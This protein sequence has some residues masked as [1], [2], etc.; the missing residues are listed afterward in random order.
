MNVVPSPATLRKKMCPLCASTIAFAIDSPSPAPT[1]ASLCTRCGAEEAVEEPILL[2][3]RNAHS[4]VGHFDAHARTVL[5]RDQLDAAAGRRE[6]EGVRDE[7]VDHLPDAP[8]VAR[9]QQAGLGDAVELDAPRRSRRRARLGALPDDRRGVELRMREREAAGVRLRREQEILDEAQQAVRIP[10]DHLEPFPLLVRLA[11]RLGVVGDE[12]EIAANRR[13]R[14]AQ[15]VR[16]EC[17]ELVLDAVELAQP[18]VLELRLREQRLAI[19]LGP[20]P[21]RDVEREALAVPRRSRRVA[22]DRVAVP[23]PDVPAVLGAEPVL[24]V[25]RL[26]RLARGR[27][28]AAHAVAVV[29]MQVVDEEVRVAVPLLLRVAEHRPDLGADEVG[30]LV[31]RVRRVHVRDQRQL[32]DEL[33][34][35]H[36]CLAASRDVLVVHADDARE[37]REQADDNGEDEDEGDPAGGERDLRCPPRRGPR[38][39]RCI[40]WARFPV[41]LTGSALTLWRTANRN[42]E[43]QSAAQCS[44]SANRASASA[45]NS[46]VARQLRARR[47]R[48]R[49]PAEEARALARARRARRDASRRA[50]ASASRST[51]VSIGGGGSGVGKPLRAARQAEAC[52]GRTARCA[53]R[54]SSRRARSP[55]SRRA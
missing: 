33:A 5:A 7:V 14:R 18:F 15:L 52:S 34:V 44:T 43:P 24:D 11:G 12:L 8:G 35:S 6:L 41:R 42:E 54:R 2:L 28:Q 16:D 23:K 39:G 4:R 25:E 1:I 17:D 38:A 50:R 30:G 21:R 29:R 32:L 49:D 51:S 47:R 9:H 20:L 40:C 37:M 27:L 10:V 13:Q 48:A 22:H 46:G 31:A 26:A 19:L 36:L 53:P 55:G 3:G 45:P